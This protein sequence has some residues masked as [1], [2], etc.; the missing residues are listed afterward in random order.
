MRIFKLMGSGCGWA[1]VLGAF[2]GPHSIKIVPVTWREGT[3]RG[4]ESNK[5][6]NKWLKS[7]K[8]VFRTPIVGILIN[9]RNTYTFRIA[10]CKTS[11]LH[12]DAVQ[13]IVFVKWR[14]HVAV[15]ESSG[16][17]WSVISLVME[18]LG[19]YHC[20]HGE[21]SSVSCRQSGLLMTFISQLQ[22]PTHLM[23]Q[24]EDRGSQN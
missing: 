19:S 14:G 11:F 18:S 3:I 15:V 8:D 10:F 1:L 12:V 7:F 4:G 5:I 21:V 17:L 23:Y 22:L 6:G 20:Y 24:K 2:V 9:W 13:H 16:D